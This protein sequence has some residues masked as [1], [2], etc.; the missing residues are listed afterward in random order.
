MDLQN[1]KR[2]LMGALLIAAAV[3]AGASCGSATPSGA[4]ASG[5]GAT[6]GSTAT[7]G[8]SSGG[9]CTAD[10]QCDDGFSC[11]VDSCVAGS[12][13]HSIGPN[14]GPTACPPGQ[15]CTVEKG[16]VASPACATN[17]DCMTAFA[18]DSCKQNARCDPSSSVCIFDL[19]DKDHDVGSPGTELEFA[20]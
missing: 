5:T 14:Q 3:I 1:M 13:A 8:S 2:A 18:G 11:T 17:A 7:H 10:S 20:L 15:F 9:T 16:C 4:G 12:C 6:S 19:L